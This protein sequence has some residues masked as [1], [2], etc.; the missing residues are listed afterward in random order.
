MIQFKGY[1]GFKPIS[2]F[3]PGREKN[4]KIYPDFHPNYPEI[5]LSEVH[6]ICTPIKKGLTSNDVS[7]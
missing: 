1:L 2:D 3:F 6:P 5:D 4:I 7:P